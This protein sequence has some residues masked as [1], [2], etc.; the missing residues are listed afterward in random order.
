MATTEPIALV[1]NSNQIQ[2]YR[3]KLIEFYG[4]EGEDFRHFHELLDSYLILSNTHSDSRKLAI[5]RSQLRRAAKVYF[6]KSILKDY[7]QV[8]YEKAIE[9]LKNHYTVLLLTA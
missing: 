3:P 4:Y 1:Q 5:L 2:G 8:T 9:L 7:P 6:E